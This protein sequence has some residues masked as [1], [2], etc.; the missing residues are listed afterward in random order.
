MPK[1]YSRQ[2]PRLLRGPSAG[3]PRV[4]DIALELISHVDGRVDSASLT[5]FVA[6]Y[7]TVTPLM[8]GELWAIPIM[9]RLA[10][11]ENLRRVAARMTAARFHRDE[12]NG[13][14]AQLNEAVEKDPKSVV[15]VLAEMT[16][17]D[18]DVGSE[19]MAEFARRL[20]EQGQT[21]ALPLMWLEHR[22]AEQGV[23]VEQLMQVEGQQQAADQVSIGNSI[24]SLRFLGAMEW[25]KFVESLSVVEQILSG[26]QAG[27]FGDTDI[28]SLGYRGII[29]DAQG[30]SDIYSEMDFGT[31]DRYRHVVE[32]VA[33]RSDCTEWEVAERAV[34][35]AKQSA[36]E[37][38]VRERS[39]H[40][41]YFLI[42]NGLPRLETAANARVSRR[43]K[44]R[45]SAK[46]NALVLHLGAIATITLATA[47]TALWQAWRHGASF[48]L[49][50]AMAPLALLGASHLGVGIVNW[51]ATLLVA[52]RPLPQMD[53]S[54]GIPRQSRTL[55]A[56]P[57]MLT[58]SD[59]VSDLI[60]ALEVRYLANRDKHLHFAL[61]TD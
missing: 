41:G 37:K 42:D 61:L 35:L 60:D 19:F 6:A 47:G 24:N 17:S 5:S 56:I 2:L 55:V 36:D 22:L 3:S 58:S 27:D 20:Q 14:A 13:W 10:L 57:T 12:A 59:G 15:L 50:A 28:S 1:K 48:W 21:M 52:P 9:L 26:Y 31:R 49:L 7:Q 43:E 25:R 40:V 16:R 45:R 53:F 33:K 44:L 23:T 30:Y 32:Q 11:I 46:R 51:L 4:Y 54:Q 29:R 34:R 39:A 8:L 38:G 18:P